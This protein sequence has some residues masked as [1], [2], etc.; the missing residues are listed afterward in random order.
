MRIPHQ[1][2]GPKRYLLDD[3]QVQKHHATVLHDYEP[4]V[5]V[6]C[7]TTHGRTFKIPLTF[8]AAIGHVK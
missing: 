6:L 3:F 1:T 4:H 7:I 2:A 8:C 5:P